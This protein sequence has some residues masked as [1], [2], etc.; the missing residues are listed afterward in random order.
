MTGVQTC[1]LPISTQGSYVWVTR[2]SNGEPVDQAT[3][4]LVGRDPKLRKSYRTDATGVARIPK[5]DYAPRLQDYDAEDDAIVIARAHAGGKQLVA[6]VVADEAS[7]LSSL[8][9]TLERTLPDY[10]V[11]AHVVRVPARP[12][13]ANGKL[14]VAALPEPDS[15]THTTYAPPRTDAET[16]LCEVWADALEIGRAHV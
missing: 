4:E 2:L 12:L 9:T 7:D 1:A 3:V 5:E 16:A 14:D 10:M 15:V 13:T 11:P 8:R 6:Y